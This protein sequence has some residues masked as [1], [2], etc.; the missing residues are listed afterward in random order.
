M[1]NRRESGAPQS[2]DRQEFVDAVGRA[3]L[4]PGIEAGEAARGAVCTLARRL[5]V[6]DAQVFLDGLPPGIRELVTCEGHRER[7]DAE[8]WS[9][10]EFLG[11][12]AEHV[13]ADVP[14]AERIARGV[15]AALQRHVRADAINAV[16]EA[17]PSD[18]EELWRHPES[19]LDASA[20]PGP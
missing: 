2:R 18:I 9:R 19:G 20:A 17:L 14:E 16:G 12:V 7:D 15:F 4:P 6:D 13:R 3:G 1:P 10:A 8:P 5:E 11:R